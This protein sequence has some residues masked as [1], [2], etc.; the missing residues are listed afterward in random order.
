MK[1]I[2]IGVTI[3]G[4]LAL[5]TARAQVTSNVQGFAGRWIGK[6]R[7]IHG[8]SWQFEI[9]VDEQGRGTSQY[10]PSPT[11]A[12]GTTCAL[13]RVKDTVGRRRFRESSATHP[14]ECNT[15]IELERETP[16]RVAFRRFEADGTTLNAT[17]ELVLTPA[18]APIVTDGDLSDWDGVPVAYR[19]PRTFGDVFHVTAV[20]LAA[21]ERF[22]F[23]Q[24]D[25]NRSVNLLAL[26]RTLSILFDADGDPATGRA[27][28]G[29]PGVDLA[30]ELSPAPSEDTGALVHWLPEHGGD[31]VDTSPNAI[32]LLA[33]SY[34]DSRAELRLDRGLTS[35]AA[36]QR[37]L[38]ASAK[39]TIKLVLNQDPIARLG[40]GAGLS[41]QQQTPAMSL[42]LPPLVPARTLNPSE[43]IPT[44]DPLARA[45][46]TA[47][48]VVTWN[49]SGFPPPRL[50]LF[51]RILRALDA[52][53]VMLNETRDR[54]S[55]TE[56]ESW[57]ATVTPDHRPWHVLPRT[58]SAV[59]VKGDVAEAFGSLSY[60]TAD[61]E[62]VHTAG[63]G[64]TLD[65]HHLLVVPLQ[66]VCCDGSPDGV[67][68]ARRMIEARLIRSAVMGALPNL[69]P[70]AIL[71]G[72]DLNLVATR[73]PLDTLRGAVADN[74][75]PLSIARASQFNGRSVDTW[76][77][78]SASGPYP[79]AQ[80]DWLLFSGSDLEQLK[81]FAFDAKD[82]SPFW[83]AAHGLQATDSR[84]SD[85]LPVVADFR[86][87]R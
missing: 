38:L 33:P 80:M 23:L 84:A 61:V 24:L 49:V 70:D 69:R 51:V 81:G 39:V 22:L 48:R 14:D 12:D 10:G 86:W 2:C 57:L 75:L 16:S 78:L 27:I 44:T 55:T 85:H 82:L 59:A 64:V 37:T 83:L 76:R 58:G 72:G 9:T 17:G 60:R 29:L 28:Y 11:P 73:G 77:S 79:P 54:M 50:D 34:A 1:H 52:D 30:V 53:V 20:R 40:Y 62:S 66:L 87:R 47:L 74:V 5:Q 8:F 45:P 18:S 41:V 31:T 26:G 35:Q 25:F 3:L 43:R 42:T 68:E 67:N 65:G 46:G 63:A 4:L 32:G 56:L 36:G 13:T 71:V 19:A 15:V 6:G 21:D 7:G